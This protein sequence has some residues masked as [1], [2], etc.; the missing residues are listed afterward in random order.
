[1]RSFP[2]PKS[3]R[4]WFHNGE[5][6]WVETYN[7]THRMNIPVPPILSHGHNECPAQGGAGYFFFS[8]GVDRHHGPPED[9][10]GFSGLY[11]DHLPGF[12][13]FF[14]VFPGFSGFSR[15]FQGF[16]RFF[17]VFPKPPVGMP[18]GSTF[19]YSPVGNRWSSVERNCVRFAKALNFSI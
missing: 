18:R 19:F 9:S 16:S 17:Q 13:R 3:Q 11:W 6:W 12:S 10:S 2:P 14:Q 7:Q 5:L 1:M 8:P 4:W 15:F